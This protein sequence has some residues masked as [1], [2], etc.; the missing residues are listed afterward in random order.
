MKASLN[1]KGNIDERFLHWDCAHL[2]AGDEL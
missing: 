1:K 2:Q